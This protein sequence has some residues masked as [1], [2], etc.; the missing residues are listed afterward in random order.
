[1][2]LYIGKS[3]FTPALVSPQSGIIPTGTIDITENGLYNVTTYANADVNISVPTPSENIYTIKMIED[4][5][6]EIFYGTITDVGNI[7]LNI[8]GD[9]STLTP[10][11]DTWEYHPA[12][13]EEIYQDILYSE[14]KYTQEKFTEILGE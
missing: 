14:H 11:R 13:I 5:E 9:S 1:M 6:N 3:K 12:D 2:A 10:L 4:V 8:L 7:T